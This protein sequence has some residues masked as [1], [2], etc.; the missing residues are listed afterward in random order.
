VGSIVR[1]LQNFGFGVPRVV[2]MY[3]FSVEEARQMAAG[4][5]AL[6]D[7]IEFFPDLESALAD[8][9]FVL[10]TTSLKRTK[11][12]L[13]PLPQAVAGFSAAQLRSTAILF[14]NEQSGLS[15]EE[16][17]RCERLITIPT[18]NYSSM[19]LSHAVGVT[20]WELHRRLSLRGTE[21][22]PELA[23]REIT[24]PMFDQMFR[25]LEEITFLH[26]GQDDRVRILLRQMFSRN[27]LTK[28]D[29]QILRG[30][31]RQISWLG[32]RT[33]KPKA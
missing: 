9:A 22:G 33:Q 21:K 27:G 19:N 3:R 30:I 8:R 18:E 26:P 28:R 10:G 24:E 23:P 7:Q 20:A 17:T 29:V 12:H 25:A 2:N 13:E 6:V 11:W 5:E 16:L 4:C 1:V 32:G 15:E 14:G 31:W